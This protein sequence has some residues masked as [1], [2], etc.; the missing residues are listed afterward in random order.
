MT[1]TSTAEPFVPAGPDLDELA[2]AA[3]ECRGCELFEKATQTVFGAGAAGATVML[4]G[5]QPGD[6]EDR[7]GV[8]LS[9]P[10]DDCW[11]VRSPRRGSSGP[12]PMSP[13]R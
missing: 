10:L 12:P 9:A 6:D 2:I 11:T 13:T 3:R 7:E 5:E 1:A 4:V 8:L